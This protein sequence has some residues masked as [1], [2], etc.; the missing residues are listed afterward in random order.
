[1]LAD[2]NDSKRKHRHNVTQRQTVATSPTHKEPSHC[3]SQGAMAKTNVN[4]CKHCVHSDSKKHT[5]NGDPDSTAPNPSEDLQALPKG[6][7][8]KVL[9]GRQHTAQAKNPQYP[10][11]TTDQDR[12]LCSQVSRP[13]GT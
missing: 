3:L 11:H 8:H 4:G 7:D 9:A 12:P 13:Q 1:M 5:T 6:H 10:T 2:K